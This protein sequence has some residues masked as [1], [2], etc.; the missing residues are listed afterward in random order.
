MRFVS[1]AIDELRLRLAFGEYLLS[2]LDGFDHQ[3][4]HRRAGLA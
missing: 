3:R 4:V 2:H 1:P